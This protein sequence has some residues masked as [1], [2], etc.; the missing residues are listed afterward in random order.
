MQCVEYELILMI[1]AYTAAVNAVSHPPPRGHVSFSRVDTA[2]RENYT[3]NDRT[4]RKVGLSGPMALY[5][6]GLL[7]KC[8]AVGDCPVLTSP[9]APP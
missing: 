1:V 9:E 7:D 3:W 2:V 4:R 6:A 8:S 5:T